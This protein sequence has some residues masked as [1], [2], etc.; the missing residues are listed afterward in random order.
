MTKNYINNKR[1]LEVITEYKQACK[2]AEEE[3]KEYPR[4]PNYVGECFYLIANRLAKRPNFYSYTYREEMIS[5]GLE[6]A[7]QCVRN[8][9][10]EK[11]NNPF[12]YFTQVIWFAFVRRIKREKKELYIKHKVT[13]NSVINGTIINGEGNYGFDAFVDLDNDYMANFV[14][15][16]EKTLTKA[17]K[18]NNEE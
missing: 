8:F 12:A 18:K 10:P 7:V 14:E 1:F 15:N 13:E 4:I 6:N 2:K 17:K 11:S 9:D 16:Y 3:G 5:D